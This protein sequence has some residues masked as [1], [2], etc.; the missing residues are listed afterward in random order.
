MFV[1]SEGAVS[2]RGWVS[3]KRPSQPAAAAANTREGMCSGS[4]P[5]DPAARPEWPEAF[6]LIQRKTRLSYTLEAPSDFPL[7]VRINAL[8]NG[9]KAALACRLLPGL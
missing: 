1:L 7:T 6:Y 2:G 9:V 5:L 8:V 3:R 4:P